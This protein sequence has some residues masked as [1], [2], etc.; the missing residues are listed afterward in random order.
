MVVINCSIYK[1]E[2]ERCLRPAGINTVLPANSSPVLNA[3]IFSKLCREVRETR[4][5]EAAATCDRFEGLETMK[6]VVVKAYSEMPPIIW[7][8][9]C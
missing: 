2:K 8:S 6:L 9:A 1:S 5:R 3:E 4:G 7:L